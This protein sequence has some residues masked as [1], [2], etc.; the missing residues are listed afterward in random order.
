M[1]SLT[2]IYVRDDIGGSQLKRIDA[3][4][5]FEAL[6][7]GCVSTTAYLSIH[8]YG[9]QSRG[10]SLRDGAHLLLPCREFNSHLHSMCAWMVDAFGSA[11][12][13]KKFGPEL[14]SMAVSVGR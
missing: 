3:A 10:S 7:T 8:K 13:R 6:S 11:E 12:L 14:T 9:G 2:G 1:G 5:I 4:V